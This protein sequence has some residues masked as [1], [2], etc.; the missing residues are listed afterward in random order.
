MDEKYSKEL[1]AFY[2]SEQK[3]ADM[4]RKAIMDEH[5]EN[6]KTMLLISVE[7]GMS[8]VTLH[9]FL[10]KKRVSVSTFRKLKNWISRRGSE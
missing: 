4:Y 7:I 5:V 3:N 10:E 8:P 1:K 2:V 6:G 9:A